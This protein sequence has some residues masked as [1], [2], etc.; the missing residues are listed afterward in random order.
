MS[1]QKSIVLVSGGIDSATCIAL[2][3]DDFE[4]VKPIHYNYGQQTSDFEETQAKKIVS[5][6]QQRGCGEIEELTVVNYEHVFKHFSGGVASEKESFVTGDGE[7]EQDD[8]R[9]TGYQPMR[10]L[11][12]LSTGAGFA[13]VNNADAIFHG[14]QAGDEADYP[15]CRPDFR[16]SAEEAINNSLADDDSVEIRTPLL[17]LEKEEVIRLGEEYNVPWEYTYSCYTAIE[18]DNPQPCGKC[19]ACIERAE[20]FYKAEVSDPFDTISVVE[21]NSPEKIETLER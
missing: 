19:P 21:Q 15:D 2:A 7:M 6:F 5:E 18:S 1:E 13:D 10:N 12:L 14:M 3:Y 20:G 4:L 9:S 11:H 16:D 8:G 17:D